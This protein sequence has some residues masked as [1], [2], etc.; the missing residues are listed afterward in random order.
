MPNSH[1]KPILNTSLPAQFRQIH[2]ELLDPE[3][4]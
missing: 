3:A 4:A 1:P 2:I